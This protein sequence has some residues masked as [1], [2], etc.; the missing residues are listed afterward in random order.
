MRCAQTIEG[1][2]WGMG[3]VTV[4]MTVLVKEAWSRAAQARDQGRRAKV[5]KL[6]ELAGR[7]EDSARCLSSRLEE[8]FKTEWYCS[9]LR[10][11]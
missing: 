5:Q 9:Y 11:G 3:Y 1:S 8:G 7:M 2:E 10:L 6:D 4:A